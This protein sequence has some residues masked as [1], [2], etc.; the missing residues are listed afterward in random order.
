MGAPASAAASADVEQL[1]QSVEVERAAAAATAAPGLGGA[2]ITAGERRSTILVLNILTARSAA[3][4]N[5]YGLHT[6]TKSR[7]FRGTQY[8]GRQSEV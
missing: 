5:S 8:V 1:L 2:A 6:A 3:P 4:L 7:R